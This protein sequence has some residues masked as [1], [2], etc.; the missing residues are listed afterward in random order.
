MANQNVLTTDSLRLGSRVRAALSTRIAPSVHVISDAAEFAGM[1]SIWNETVGRAALDHPFLRHEWLRTWWDCFGAGRRLHIVVVKSAGRIL[2]IAPLMWDTARMYGVPVRRLQLL[3]N[4]HTPHAD[5][6]V[7]E[8]P[9]ESYRAI[10]Q[11]L[12]ETSEQWDVLQLS[13]V[14][15][16]S[17]T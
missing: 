16:A 5:V 13:H 10:W 7:A 17:P 12:V 2:A 8:R 11:S 1:E 14:H 3:A 6:I 4:D 9:Q 15:R